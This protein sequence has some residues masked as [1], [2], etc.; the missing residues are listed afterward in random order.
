MVEILTD[1]EVRKAMRVDEDYD[2]DEVTSYQKLSTAFVYNKTG[3]FSEDA[4]KIND[5]AKQLARLY[6]KTQF[7]T[8]DNYKQDYDYSLGI[9][10]LIQDLQGIVRNEA[11]DE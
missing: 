8:S 10:G 4:D 5:L 3:Y 7:Y 2:D 9:N 1:L 11:E 6:V